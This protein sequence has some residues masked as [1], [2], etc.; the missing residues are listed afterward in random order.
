MLDRAP[1]P[2]ICSLERIGKPYSRFCRRVGQSTICGKQIAI[3]ILAVLQRACDGC[4]TAFGLYGTLNFAA[5][6]TGA[7]ANWV[8]VG[9]VLQPRSIGVYAC[10][11]IPRHNVRTMRKKL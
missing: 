10:V 1:S 8:S 9:L 3:V 6:L 5:I 4:Q 11:V 7:P 2:G